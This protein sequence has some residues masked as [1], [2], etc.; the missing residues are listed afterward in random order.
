MGKNKLA[1]F[2]RGISFVDNVAVFIKRNVRLSDDM[3][4]FFPGS[5]VKRVRL[6]AGLIAAS[7]DAFVGFIDVLLRHMIIRLELR[8]TAVSDAHKFSH[9]AVDNFPVW[10]FDEAKRVDAGVARQ[11]RD[12]PDVRT[13]RRLDRANAPVVGGVHVADFE[14][15]ALTAQPAR[16]QRGQSALVSNFR[17]WICLIHELRQL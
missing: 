17:K 3:F 7:A 12:Q 6:V 9:H 2:S 4:V 15:G 5:Q 1:G 8:I 13:F 10:R 11:R 16:S 14:S